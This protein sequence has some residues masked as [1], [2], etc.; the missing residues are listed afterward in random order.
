LG[1]F[2]DAEPWADFLDVGPE[3]IDVAERAIVERLMP[4]AVNP[5]ADAWHVIGKYDLGPLMHKILDRT[6]ER[7]TDA[8]EEEREKRESSA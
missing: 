8:R 4:D 5:S 6:A 2:A 7:G 1:N 3:F